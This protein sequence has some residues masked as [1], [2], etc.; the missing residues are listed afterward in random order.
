MHSKILIQSSINL[1]TYSNL[2]RDGPNHQLVLGFMKGKQFLHRLQKPFSTVFSAWDDICLFVYLRR[3]CLSSTVHDYYALL[4]NFADCVGDFYDYFMHWL[5]YWELPTQALC[6]PSRY[7]TF[8]IKAETLSLYVLKR[9][10]WQSAVLVQNPAVHHF[11]HCNGCDFS[12]AIHVSI[13]CLLRFVWI[14]FDRSY[15]LAC[16]QAPQL[17]V[18]WFAN[19]SWVQVSCCCFHGSEGGLCLKMVLW[20]SI[21]GPPLDCVW[22]I[23]YWRGKKFTSVPSGLWL[24]HS[25]GMHPIQF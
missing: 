15:L 9:G 14:K 17:L 2:K 3:P 21:S 16:L 5:V 13:S 1:R 4:I 20:Y 11:R 18:P 7:E 6:K 10:N 19:C 8:W 25:Y 12:I 24:F 23:L 22:A